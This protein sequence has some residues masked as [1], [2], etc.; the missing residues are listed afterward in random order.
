LVPQDE[1]SSRQ[2]TTAGAKPARLR[3]SGSSATSRNATKRHP[4]LTQ[5][6][7]H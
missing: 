4:N 3:E 7:T 6:L 2:E 1:I 5:I